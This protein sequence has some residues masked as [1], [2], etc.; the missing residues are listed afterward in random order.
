MA[1]H[2][3]KTLFKPTASAGGSLSRS[4][5]CK[6]HDRASPEMLQT[7]ANCCK[8]LQTASEDHHKT[9][10]VCACG[11]VHQC[12]NAYLFFRGIDNNEI[13]QGVLLRFYSPD[14]ETQL[15]LMLALT[16]F[17]ATALAWAA[18]TSTLPGVF[19][20]SPCK[21]KAKLEDCLHSESQCF[22]CTMLHLTAFQGVSSFPFRSVQ[23]ERWA[24]DWW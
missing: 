14:F 21:K 11:H 15:W 8:L 7:V 12:L 6:R 1:T 3:S 19:S 16:L 18:A 24:D 10:Y 2:P 13:L 20:T 23:L 9:Y 17:K 5:A 22:T 4:K